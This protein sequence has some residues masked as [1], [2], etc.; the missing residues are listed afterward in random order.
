M[1]VHCYERLLYGDGSSQG[2]ILI[3]LGSS[4]LNTFNALQEGRSASPQRLYTDGLV[5]RG[6]WG[7]GHASCNQDPAQSL[8]HAGW[9]P[10][11]L[12]TPGVRPTGHGSHS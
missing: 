10:T 6:S 5:D 7:T 9:D 3:P 8:S 12:V 2:H 11:A 4:R 1:V